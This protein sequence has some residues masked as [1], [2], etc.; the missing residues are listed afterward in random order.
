MNSP[1]DGTAVIVIFY[2]ISY[3]YDCGSPS[4]ECPSDC[5]G[6]YGDSEFIVEEVSTTG[7]P[8][9]DGHWYLKFATFSAHYGSQANSTGTYAGSDLEYGVAAPSSN[10]FVWVAEDK[11]SNYRSQAVCDAGAY[12]FDNCDRPGTRVGLEVPSNANL[13]AQNRQLNAFVGSRVGGIYSGTE[14]MWSLSL[15]DGFLG[16][17]P[18]SFGQG[19]TPY[20]KLL[21][22]YGF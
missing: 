1:I 7:Y 22:N 12:Y 9:Y 2:A 18:R 6:H 4:P 21:N 11:H 3:H 10:P 16:W 17:Y 5:G 15:T 14:H 8:T 13:G 19:E 20:G